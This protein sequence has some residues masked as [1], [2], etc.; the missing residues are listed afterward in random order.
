MKSVMRCEARLLLVLFVLSL[1]S[2]LCSVDLY[3]FVVSVDVY[4]ALY[5]RVNCSYLKL[6]CFAEEVSVC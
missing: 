3:D 1:G 2:S 5:G 4:M 6:L